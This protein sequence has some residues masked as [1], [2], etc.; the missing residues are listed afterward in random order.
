M[1]PGIEAAEIET[2]GVETGTAEKTVIEAPEMLQALPI[3]AVHSIQMIVATSAETE[4]I[5]LGIAAASGPVVAREEDLEA[6]QLVAGNFPNSLLQDLLRCFYPNR[7]LRDSKS[8]TA[9]KRSVA[10]HFDPFGV[11]LLLQATRT[12]LSRKSTRPSNLW[13]HSGRIQRH[14][15]GWLRVVEIVQRRLLDESLRLFHN[16]SQAPTPCI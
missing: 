10:H 9:S 2:E 3:M 15:F 1:D 13:L 6:D 12:R 5:M 7:P 8:F 4:A 16:S 14:S 11:W